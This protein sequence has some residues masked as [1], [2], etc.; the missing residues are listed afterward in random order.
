MTT[1]YMKILVHTANSSLFPDPSLVVS[2]CDPNI[3][4]IERVVRD[5]G[6][7]IVVEE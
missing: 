3:E 7:G 5:V 4:T 6:G 2:I 1:P